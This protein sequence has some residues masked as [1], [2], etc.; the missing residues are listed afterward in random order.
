MNPVDSTVKV[1]LEGQPDWVE[2]TAARL[3]QFFTVTY[4]SKPHRVS[5][6]PHA[7]QLYLRVLPPDLARDLDFQAVSRET[8]R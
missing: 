8:T 5:H 2:A 7:K 4:E 1:T 6:R 3:K